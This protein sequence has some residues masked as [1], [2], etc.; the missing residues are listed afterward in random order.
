[1][2]CGTVENRVGSVGRRKGEGGQRSGDVSRSVT[3]VEGR[4]AARGSEDSRCRH[5]GKV[6][7]AGVSYRRWRGCG[8]QVLARVR[9]MGQ[10]RSSLEGS[11][12]ASGRGG[13]DPGRT[14]N[15]GGLTCALGR[16]DYAGAGAGAGA[17]EGSH[18]WIWR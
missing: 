17:R 8:Q 1:M 3:V 15:S 6:V 16:I 4:R 13:Q 12:G 18:T 14:G 2:G 10:A 11:R 5:T 7:G 9:V